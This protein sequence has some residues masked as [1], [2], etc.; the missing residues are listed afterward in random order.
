MEK[1]V[2]LIG[3][4]KSFMVSAIEKGLTRE[5]FEV[6]A[7]KPSIN[8]L[9]RM[10]N[11]PTLILLY[12][13]QELDRDF[14][15]FLKDMINEDGKETLLYPIGSEDELQDLY[16]IVVPELTGGEFKRPINVNEI[17]SV[18]EEALE[19]Q[20]AAADRRKILVVD[21][22]GTMLR[23]LKLWLSS[24][25]RVYIA[26]SGMAAVT[27]LAKNT[28][29]LILL[30]YEMP[31]ANGLTVLEM[32][33]SEPQTKN[34][35]VMFLTAKSDRNIVMSVMG[36]K[37]EKYLLKSMSSRELIANIDEFFESNSRI[38]R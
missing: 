1:R 4:N 22:D 19:K 13:D 24:K 8:D 20:S 16:E 31:V 36:L 12:L 18:L 25:Y 3:D 6:T 35:P 7:M 30:D 21:D 15:I 14:L 33:R 29:D 2:L 17:A 28:V 9:S 10:E 37:P 11:R 26:N 5:N 32:L 23:T 38:N 34:I 27:F